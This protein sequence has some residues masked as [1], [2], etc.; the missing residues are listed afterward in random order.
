MNKHYNTVYY[1]LFFYLSG[2]GCPP[3]GVRTLFGVSHLVRGASGTCGR[4]SQVVMQTLYL[5]AF[6]FVK[7][8]VIV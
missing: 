5:E 4:D 2:Q 3:I 1:L 7:S 8:Y 6:R